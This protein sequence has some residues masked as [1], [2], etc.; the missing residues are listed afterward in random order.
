[1]K[2]A[3]PKRETCPVS[4][5]RAEVRAAIMAARGGGRSIGFVPTM[6]ALH[7]GHL[8]LVE[9]SRAETDFTVVSIFVNPT[10]F[11][12]GEDFDRYPRDLAADVGQL[13]PLG[14]DLVFAPPGAEIYR[15]AETTM[16]EPAAV[17]KRLEGEFRPGHFR[18]VATVVLKLF[19]IVAPDVAF[20]GQ[21]D[22]QQSLVVRRLVAD[23]DL[24][25]E[26]R[27]CPTVREPDGL[28]M[29]SRNAYLTPE[30]R[31]WALVLSCSLRR[32]CDLFNSG[33][34]DAATI[35][36][37]MMDLFEAESGVTVDYLAL[38]DGD[39]LADVREVTLNTVALV[40]ARVGG[41]RLIDNCF[42]SSQWSVG[43]G[44]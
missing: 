21:K 8:S 26:I 37:Q 10:Q 44:Q 9:A 2:T 32:A 16:V 40:A 18:G 22:F 12:P 31:R 25:V 11:G 24:P 13:A 4:T 23:L 30:D 33:Q 14:V 6:G 17:A 35:K 42:L 3:S 15:A 36:Q 39:T 20:F 5:T 28:A 43:S 7:T 1:M 29:S 41:V 19:N 27:V 34:R 38:A